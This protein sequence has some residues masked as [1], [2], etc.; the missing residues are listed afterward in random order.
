MLGEAAHLIPYALLA[1]LS[2]LGLAA[3]ITVMRTGRLGAFCFA[4]GALLGQLLTCSILVVVGGF[5]IPSNDSSHGTIQGVLDLCLGIALL[6]LAVVIHRRP[7]IV[8]SGSNRSSGRSK[9]VLER[10]ARVRP[11]TAVAAG[12]MLGIGGPKRLVV[13]TLASASIA[14]TGLTGSDQLTLILWYSALATIVVWLPV[15]SYL[16][17]GQSA[18]NQVDRG[19]EWLA[20]HRRSATMG[21]LV[22]LGVVLLANAGAAL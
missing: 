12:V 18:V 6:S 3:T 20:R 13:A 16:L 11:F 17:L 21:A 9:R 1:T 14:A 8:T 15:L 5:S 4:F 19:L 22:L 2:P 10:L 7:S